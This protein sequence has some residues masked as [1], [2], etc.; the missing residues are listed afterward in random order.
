MINI[1]PKN[2]LEP[3]DFLE[4][5]PVSIETNDDE[6][7]SSYGIVTN[8]NNATTNI[9]HPISE[10]RASRRDNSLGMPLGYSLTKRLKLTENVEDERRGSVSSSVSGVDIDDKDYE[11]QEIYNDS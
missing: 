7:P 5:S 11:N 8:N 3:E 2:S 9:R 10:R 6:K 4:N 1:N